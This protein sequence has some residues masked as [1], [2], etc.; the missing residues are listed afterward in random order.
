MVDTAEQVF[1]LADYG[2][3]Q[4]QSVL[5]RGDYTDI[6]VLLSVRGEDGKSKI[7]S[8]K[9]HKL[10]LA[11]WSPV[12]K[13]LMEK[14][15]QEGHPNWVRLVDFEPDALKS[16]ILTFYTGKLTLSADN[17]WPARTGGWPVLV[18]AVVNGIA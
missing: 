15:V 17:V 8:L 4:L 7:D 3:R 1:S 13:E 16:M 5:D 2:G 9:C 10:V 6:T 11:A 14:A 18:P 12:F